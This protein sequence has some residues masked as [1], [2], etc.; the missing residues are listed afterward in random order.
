MKGKVLLAS[1]FILTGCLGP[2]DRMTER[3]STNAMIK[4]N[5]VCVVSAL[6][7]G[8]QITAIQINGDKNDTLHKIFDDKPVYV[9]KGEC[10]PLFGFTFT[11]GEKYSVAY[12]VMNQKLQSHLVM[13]D[14]FTQIDNG[15]IKI[16]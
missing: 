5:Q 12:E 16:F 7:S 11:P 14:F 8:E 1:V 3:E 2:G 6:K 15:V 9:A 4:D 10:L 13:A